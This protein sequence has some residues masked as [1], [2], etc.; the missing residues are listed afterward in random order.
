MPSTR[1]IG[2]ALLLFFLPHAMAFLPVTALSRTARSTKVFFSPGSGC[3]AGSFDA[4]T[5]AS[6]RTQHRRSTSSSA[7]TMVDEATIIG[8]VA[9]LAGCGC[10]IGACLFMEYSAERTEA[11]GALT[12]EARMKYSA[13]FMED[14]NA[15]YQMRGGVDVDDLTYRMRQ[16]L[17]A[18]KSDA[19]LKEEEAKEL[20]AAAAPKPEENDDGW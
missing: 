8:S 14:D 6:V 19:E 11:K 4:G 17:R 2:A 13:K 7:L 10:G 3:G 12:E 5:V 16:A 15:A 18:N 1:A 9:A 20:Q